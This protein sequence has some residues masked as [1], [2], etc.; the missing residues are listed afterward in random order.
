M[1]W[2][3]IDKRLIK[4]GSIKYRCE[5]LSSKKC[6]YIYICDKTHLTF[7]FSLLY[8]ILPYFKDQT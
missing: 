3:C 5:K 4:Y 8:L 6:E 7:Y 2:C 1:F